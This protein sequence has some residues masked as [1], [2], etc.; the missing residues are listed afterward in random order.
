M[1]FGDLIYEGRQRLEFKFKIIYAT[2]LYVIKL[3]IF[4]N[5]IIFVEGS[6]TAHGE[7]V[8]RSNSADNDE[9]MRLKL[10]RK[11][12]RNRTSFTAEQLEALEKGIYFL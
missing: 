2:L 5:F 11:L 3:T 8:K 9:Q 4:A 12:Q 10:K 1:K 7:S 6:T